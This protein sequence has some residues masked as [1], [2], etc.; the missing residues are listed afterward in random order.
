[1]IKEEYI[2]T[3]DELTSDYGVDLSNYALDTSMI[4][5]IIRIAFG[6]AV[7]RVLYFNDTFKYEEDI[8]KALDSKPQLV[9]AFKKLQ[10]QVV[11]N[12][13]FLGDNDPLDK[14][15]DDIICSDLRWGKIN[16]YQKHVFT[17]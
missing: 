2:I 3:N 10:F 6:K 15:V 5:M 7:T 14:Q 4:P 12:L 8:E 9:S 11:Y 13:I 1:M 16:G 17:R